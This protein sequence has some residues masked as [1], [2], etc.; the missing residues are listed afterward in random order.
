MIEL[1]KPVE[2][3][4][5]PEY[6]DVMD[7]FG[8]NC[9]LTPWG[10]DNMLFDFTDINE[11]YSA[12]PFSVAP[13]FPQLTVDMSNYDPTPWCNGCGAKTKAA[14]KCGPTDPMD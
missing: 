11:F 6:D 5:L 10:E 9:H 4:I 3:Y 7:R 12:F 8:P 13:R 14:C 2:G 1:N